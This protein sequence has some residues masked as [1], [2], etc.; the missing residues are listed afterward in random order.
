MKW[1]MDIHMERGHTGVGGD[2]DSSPGF[3]DGGGQACTERCHHTPHRTGERP[4]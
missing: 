2:A 4:P 3:H 1:H